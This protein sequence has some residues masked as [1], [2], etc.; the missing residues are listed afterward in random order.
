MRVF[1]HPAGKKNVTSET[2]KDNGLNAA[3]ILY[4]YINIIII[5]AM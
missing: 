3:Q 2:K 5:F 4:K 1:E